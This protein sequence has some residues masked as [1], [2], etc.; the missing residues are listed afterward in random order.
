MWGGGGCS[1]CRQE[2]ECHFFAEY[3]EL[4]RVVLEF[5]KRFCCSGESS[6][7]TNT[8]PKIC[9]CLKVEK[10]EP[11]GFHYKKVSHHSESGSDWIHLI[12]FNLC[13]QSA[14]LIAQW[15]K[16]I[17]AYFAQVVCIINVE[18]FSPVRILGLRYELRLARLGLRRYATISLLIGT[19][20]PSWFI[21]LVSSS[22]PGSEKIR[23]CQRLW[24]NPDDGLWGW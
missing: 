14:K 6:L 15:L 17:R 11:P 16:K 4:L 7:A 19:W 13:W 5:C 22:W 2:R 24:M 20:W 18:C 8:Y 23:S 12:F 3:Q 1:L 21:I 10:S 9:F